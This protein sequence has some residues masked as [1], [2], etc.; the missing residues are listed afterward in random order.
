M[1]KKL[2]ALLLTICV[3]IISY[4]S[5]SDDD[6]TSREFYIE[7]GV[8]SLAFTK[9]S[10]Q[11][12]LT[13]ETN[14]PQ[15][16]IDVPADWCKVTLNGY[17]LTIDVEANTEIGRETVITIS[18]RDVVKTINI[19]QIGINVPPVGSI[20]EDAMVPI[21][22]ATA[23]TFN[24]DNPIELSFDG[25]YDTY[26]M[27]KW[28]GTEFPV[29]VIY[30]FENV[31][32]MDYFIYYPR[33]GTGTNGLLGKLE[34]WY[35]TQANPGFTKLGDFDFQQSRVSVRI[36]FP[37]T[38]VK[39]T[40][41]KFLLGQGRGSNGSGTSATYAAIGEME[42]YK[43][44]ETFDLL[45]IF[46]DYACSELKTGIGLPEI[47]NIKSPFYKYLATELYNKDYESEFRI[48]EYKVYQ[49]P[50]VMATANKT[51]RY[52]LL[53]NP[54]G[55]YVDEGEDLVVL[56]NDPGN[57]IVS[58]HIIDLSVGYDSSSSYAI[59]KGMNKIKTTSKGLA[60]VLYHTETATENPIK[61]N[62]VTGKVN[63][64]FDSERHNQEDWNRLLNNAVGPYFDVLGK[65]S[66]ATYPTADF[67]KY[68]SDGLALIKKY[69]EMVYLEM[70]FMGLVKYNKLFKNRMYFHIHYGDTHMF[71]SAY[72]TAY[73]AKTMENMCNLATFTTSCWGPA[74]EVGHVNQTRP[75][76][77]WQGMTEVTNNVHSLHVQTTFGNTSRLIKDN[78]YEKAFSGNNS[79][80]NSGKGHNES[81]D[82]FEKLIPFWQ[83]K[84]Y[85][86]D[87]LNK[88]DF[89]KD[90]YEH[91]RVTSTLSATGLTEGVYQLDFVRNTCKVANLD[92][93]TFFETW[94]F[95]TPVSLTVG[96][97]GDKPFIITQQQI[98]DLKNEIAS[99][100]YPKPKHSNIH[101]I[102]DVNVTDYR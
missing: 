86:M 11:E 76:M 62:I 94:G 93:T 55:I 7:V 80:I 45:S 78:V 54:T 30:N 65:Y 25:K 85:M 35:A 16:K 13:L 59:I 70:E 53:D 71:A 4:T 97:Y 31:E 50:N 48:Q 18:G 88:S 12:I 49:H 90:L 17:T 102:T 60:Y 64:Y 42:F 56:A 34:V 26:F 83:L 5:C 2:I 47:E 68:T 72:H 75:G 74:H 10:A 87:V 82:F 22:S 100:N 3:F 6:E 21:S 1:T 51:E 57:S 91:Y 95:L 39:P 67:K 29:E 8:D 24:K 32:A 81:T 52:S 61:I 84:L 89:Y 15:I 33:G 20:P 27:T 99:K 63:G 14:T 73:S 9:S 43:K 66:H 37:A 92:L 23:G 101:L 41:V 98:D 58:L 44:A 77:R 19:S 40:Q 46:N 28:S 79:I 36:D 96:D 38:L 69:D